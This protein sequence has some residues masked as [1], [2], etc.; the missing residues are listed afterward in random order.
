[1]KH[2]PY[3]YLDVTAVAAFL[4]RLAIHRQST[5]LN[6][7]VT[8][9]TIEMYLTN[10]VR[11]YAKSHSNL[12]KQQLPENLQYLVMYV[13]GLLKQGFMSPYEPKTNKAMVTL[14][15]LDPMTFLK[16]TLNHFSPEEALPLFNPWIMNIHDYNLSDQALPALEP[17]DRSVMQKA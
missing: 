2:L 12:N 11:A 10:I 8:R 3:E 4:S 15:T 9:S 13:L 16:F 7:Q 1:M 5:N 6:F 17:L 14:E